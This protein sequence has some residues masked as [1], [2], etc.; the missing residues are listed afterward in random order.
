MDST[1]DFKQRL[2]RVL[3]TKATLL[4][5]VHDNTFSTF[6]L[7]KEALHE[8]ASELNEEFEG[9]LD[10]RIRIEYRDRGKFEAQLQVAGETLLF[11]MHTDVFVFEPNNAIWKNEYVKNNKFNAYC[12]VI[13]IYN[14]LSDSFKHNR[15][16]DDGYLIGRIFINHEL[17]YYADGTRQ[18]SATIEQFG[19]NQ[20][21]EERLLE[22]VQTAVEFALDFDLF[23]PPIDVSKIST[24]AQFNTKFENS[25]I[26]TGK[27]LGYDF[28]YLDDF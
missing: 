4:Q 11:N 10:R 17:A 18:N 7:L 27:R 22:V 24:L 21:T 2:R 1:S 25:K 16:A 3:A 15:S 12:G 20:I 8:M 19:E 6:N 26:K 13:D 9:E 28:D 14:F 23:I 5:K